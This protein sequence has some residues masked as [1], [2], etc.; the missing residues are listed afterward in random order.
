M[1]RHV[2]DCLNCI[3]YWVEFNRNIFRWLPS[4]LSLWLPR[5]RSSEEKN[6]PLR[7]IFTHIYFVSVSWESVCSSCWLKWFSVLLLILLQT[8]ELTNLIVR[9]KVSSPRGFSLPVSSTLSRSTF[10]RV[11]S[12][13]RNLLVD[14]EWVGAH[15]CITMVTCTH[16]I[17]RWGCIQTELICS[18]IS[19]PGNRWSHFISTWCVQ[20]ECA[21][22]LLIYSLQPIH[23]SSSW[24]WECIS[25]TLPLDLH[26]FWCHNRLIQFHALTFH[27]LNSCGLFYWNSWL[28]ENYLSDKYLIP[29]NLQT[30]K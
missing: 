11:S 16:L 29:S 5:R 15:E 26:L 3:E 28:G 20:H 13:N 4:G 22:A 18:V 1:L 17:N 30:N 6:I 12:K 19:F 24:T 21:S 2:N 23:M 7:G 9:I 14:H 25:F 27:P 10:H 8:T